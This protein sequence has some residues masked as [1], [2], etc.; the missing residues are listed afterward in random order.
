MSSRQPTALVT[1]G[2][3]FIGNHLAKALLERG[4]AVRIIDDLS[5]GQKRRVDALGPAVSFTQGSILDPAALVAAMKGAEV[6]FHHAALAGVPQ[7][8]EQ[9]MEYHEVDATGTLRVLEAAR[10]AGVRRVIYAASSSAYGEQGGGP[11]N[12]SMLP[13]P[14]SPYA[15]AKRVGELYVSVYAR[16]YGLDGISL[17]Y[18]NVFG[19]HQD[20]KS[21]YGA[22]I[23]AIVARMIRG[24][25]P[26]IFGDGR[27][28]RDFCY[29]ENVVQANLLAA[30]APGRL[31][32]QV[33]NIAC[34][35][36][37]TINDV[38]DMT[39]HILGTSLTPVHAPPRPGD[40][41]DSLADVGLA[42]KVLHY[43]PKVFFEDGLRR[44]IE[45]YRRDNG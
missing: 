37:V 44:W 14:I 39:N 18:F 26:T 15:V 29:V 25:R 45:W 20:P 31:E 28:T 23:P 11:K 21:Q 3:G 7:S 10:R 19:P 34:G 27:Q 38:V 4:W 8:V 6:V 16:I 24:E 41:R 17:R 30:E 33:V 13:A 5:N 1:G 35:R 12:E 43:E 32:G 2:A 9:P 36:A 42:G 40:V 22:A